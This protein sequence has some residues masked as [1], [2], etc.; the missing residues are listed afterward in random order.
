MYRS[1]DGG[2]ALSRI[3]LRASYAPMLSPD[4]SI[5]AYHA[6]ES[7]SSHVYNL[8]L[9][10]MKPGAT[11]STAARSTEETKPI[12]WSRDGRSLY[13]FRD[14]KDE[15]GGCLVRVD[16]SSPARANSL[17]CAVSTSEGARLLVAPDAK[18]GALIGSRGGDKGTIEVKWIALPDGAS[19][20]TATVDGGIQPFYCGMSD[21]G[22]IACTCLIDSAGTI[23][24]RRRR[25][26]G[27]RAAGCATRS[28]SKRSVK[29][30]RPPRW[31]RGTRSRSLSSR[32]DGRRLS[33][34]T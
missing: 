24:A 32:S 16:V 25:T 31:R 10:P 22:R 14:G 18:L 17:G 23:R 8:Q 21:S 9:L 7:A 27:K 29:L 6:L 33:L 19:A 3:D 13:A 34:P 1:L 5:G 11:P 26:S 20:G 2:R 30:G 15:K 4:G 12:A 28:S